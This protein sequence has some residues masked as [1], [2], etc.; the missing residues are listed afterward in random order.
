MQTHQLIE[1]ESFYVIVMEYA[2]GGELFELIKERPRMGEE[3][4]RFYV[5]ETL[6]AIRYLHLNGVIYRDV[7]PENIILDHEGHVKLTDFG[8]AKR[9][10]ER[11]YSFCG[12][13]D[14]MAPEVIT[15]YG[16]GYE[17]DYYSVGNLMYELLVGS[18]PF[19]HP[20]FSQEETKYHIL[21]TK[22]FIPQH[23]KL[24]KEAVSLL[25]LLLEKDPGKRIG[26]YGGV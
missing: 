22:I 1:S 26:H 19:Y 5:V 24:S 11:S 23:I 16:Y 21:N 7:K 18:P 6:L 10:N 15:D 2:P 20:N 3:E 8:L 4:V 17:I 25:E 14:Y 13:L 12:S 9:G